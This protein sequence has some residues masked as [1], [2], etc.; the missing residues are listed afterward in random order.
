MQPGKGEDSSS[1][2]PWDFAYIN[3]RASVLASDP[4][5]PLS[6]PQS[7]RDM[8]ILVLIMVNGS[9]VAKGPLSAMMF[10]DGMLRAFDASPQM[11]QEQLKNTVA[12]IKQDIY[13]A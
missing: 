3:N 5:R 2:Q 13:S 1:G 8:G 6:N 11:S 9:D 4:D 10:A 7:L 12:R